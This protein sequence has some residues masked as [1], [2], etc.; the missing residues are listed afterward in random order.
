MEEKEFE[1]IDE[2][3][4]ET[5]EE[6]KYEKLDAFG[7]CIKAYLDSLAKKDEYFACMYEADRIVDCCQYIINEVKGTKRNAF[8]DDEIFKMARDF[9]VDHKEAPKDKVRATVKV[10]TTEKP[11]EQKVEAEQ[12]S[13]FDI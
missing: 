9:Y 1:E 12:L 6:E 4:E 13:L 2:M 7:I 10:P 5:T 11:K 3:E 8:T